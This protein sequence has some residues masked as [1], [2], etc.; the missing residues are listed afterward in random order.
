MSI[1]IETPRL[2]LRKFRPDDLD[3]LCRLYADPDVRRYF[4]DG[5]LDREATR[6]EFEWFLNGDN[7]GFPEHGLWATIHRPTGRFIGRCGLLHWVIEGREETEIAYMIS[8]EFWRQ[9]LGEEAAKALVRHGFN[10]LGL[11]RLIALID[12]ENVASM[13]TAEKAGL[14]FERVVDADGPAHMYSIRNLL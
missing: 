10:F 14:R 11:S 7:P 1:V 12:A 9:G 4:P 3:D 5:A 13:R 6:D 2:I 8:S